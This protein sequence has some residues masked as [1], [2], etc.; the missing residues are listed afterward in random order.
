MTDFKTYWSATDKVEWE[1]IEPI[2]Q[3]TKSDI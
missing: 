1:M 2:I 3:F